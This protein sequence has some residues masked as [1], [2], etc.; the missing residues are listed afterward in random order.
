MEVN[1]KFHCPAVLPPGKEIPEL[2]LSLFCDVTQRMLV[3]VS[4][5]FFELLS[6]SLRNT[7]GERKRQLHRDGNQKSLTVLPRV[8]LDILENKQ[9]TSIC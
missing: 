4:L 8:G 9:I 6:Q 7:S 1:G 3:V 5:R 2:K